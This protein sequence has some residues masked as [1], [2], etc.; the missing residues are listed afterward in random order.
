M[1]YENDDSQM[2]MMA[3]NKFERSGSVK[4]CRSDDAESYESMYEP[5]NAQGWQWCNNTN[6]TRSNSVGSHSLSHKTGSNDEYCGDGKWASPEDRNATLAQLA[7]SKAEAGCLRSEVNFLRHKITT[8]QA[9]YAENDAKYE[10]CLA[11][12]RAQLLSAQ[13]AN[14]R[15][16]AER[17][18]LRKRLMSIEMTTA[19]TLSSDEKPE[20]KLAPSDTK[21]TEESSEADFV[22]EQSAVKD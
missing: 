1:R 18:L 6:Q 3:S 15:T 19:T 9:H 13:S 14:Q 20:G 11:D 2:V 12:L 5:Q 7:A 16:A 4:S 17:D 21:S 8:W 22:V 10:R